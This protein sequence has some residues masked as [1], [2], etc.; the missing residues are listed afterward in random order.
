[1]QV[2][3][4]TCHFD[5]ELLITSS[6]IPVPSSSSSVLN[7]SAAV[8]TSAITLPLLLTHRYDSGTYSPTRARIRQPETQLLIVRAAKLI[9]DIPRLSEFHDSLLNS[10][11]GNCYQ[12]LITE[13]FP[14]NT[15]AKTL[16]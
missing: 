13:S 4:F 7:I 5:F 16:F 15:Y 12:R 6:L 8:A 1:M 9:S 3:S 10:G 14:R 11:T 2:C